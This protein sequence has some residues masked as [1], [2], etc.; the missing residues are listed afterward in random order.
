LNGSAVSL[1]VVDNGDSG[2][3]T[4]GEMTLKMISFFAKY[5]DFLLSATCFKK[6]RNIAGGED[7]YQIKNCV[8]LA[9]N[10]VFPRSKAETLFGCSSQEDSQKL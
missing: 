8:Q 7:S 3:T 2:L 10:F 6:F 5:H 9:N 1:V 4:R